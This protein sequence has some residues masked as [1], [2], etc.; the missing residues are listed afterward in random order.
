VLQYGVARPPA[1]CVF[2]VQ[3]V[4]Q[5]FVPVLQRRPA[6]PHWLAVVHWTHRWV[7]VSHTLAP[8]APPAHSALAL[9]DTTQVCVVWSHARPASPH[10]ASLTHTTHWLVVVSQVLR[11][12]WVAQL[13][14]AVHATQIP[15]DVLHAG[16]APVVH[17]VLLVQP[18]TH[19]FVAVLQTIPASPQSELETQ[20]THV[21]AGEQVRAVP[22]VHCAFDVQ[23]T[24]RW[25]EVQCVRPPVVQFESARH[26]TQELVDVS[27]TGVGAAH[28]PLS[29]QGMPAEP[30]ELEPELPPPELPPELLP[31]ELLPESAP[32]PSTVASSPLPSL[33]ESPPPSAP[34]LLAV[35]SPLVPPEDEPEELVVP[36][37]P[38]EEESVLS[39]PASAPPEEPL[40]PPDVPPLDEPPFD[41]VSLFDPPH[42]TP[43]AIATATATSALAEEPESFIAYLSCRCGSSCCRSSRGSSGRS[44][45]ARRCS[46]SGCKPDPRGSPR[47]WRPKGSARS[48]PRWCCSRA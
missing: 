5:R 14:S 9:H 44:G 30:P 24:Q 41:P 26:S 28:M 38:E 42:A 22:A 6:S 46:R 7:V 37:D 47:S 25:L 27:Q 48:S 12:A 23:A 40:A 29:V 19:W 16:A 15:V 18:A 21:P 31:P 10:C 4:A 8:A 33:A 36:E 17:W 11:V 2:V 3:P 45:I 43:T 13:A 20:R 35:E 32:E 39:S 1:H 34:E